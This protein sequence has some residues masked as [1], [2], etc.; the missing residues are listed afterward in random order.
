MALRGRKTIHGRALPSAE[1]AIEELRE[2]TGQDFGPDTKKW[3][4]WI[5]ENRRRLY[6][7]FP[8]G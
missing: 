1:E 8:P 3:A 2:I 6:K 5:K 7:T 4:A